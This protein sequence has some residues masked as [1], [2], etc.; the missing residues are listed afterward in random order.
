MPMPLPESAL[1]SYCQ[2]EPREQQASKLAM[3]YGKKLI[4]IKQ[5]TKVTIVV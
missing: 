4:M 3:P 1:L 5:S 2:S